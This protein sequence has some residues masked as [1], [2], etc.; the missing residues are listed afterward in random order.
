MEFLVEFGFL[1]NF[2]D[3][4]EL[5]ILNFLAESFGMR[6]TTRLALAATFLLAVSMTVSAAEADRLK[7]LYLG[8]GGHHQPAV[9]FKQLQP[10]L[11]KQKIDLV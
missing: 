6:L 9:R 3:S 8:D 2:I 7:L 11:A 4:F 5:N 1:P 10:A